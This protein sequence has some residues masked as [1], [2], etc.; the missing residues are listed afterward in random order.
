MDRFRAGRGRALYAVYWLGLSVLVLALDYALGPI[1]Q[2]PAAFIL[3]VS[4]AAWY[5]GRLWGLGLALVLPLC[6][7]YL[8]S[9]SDLP[10]TMGEASINAAIRMIVLGLFAVLVDRVAV[11]REAL[12]RRVEVL[13]GFLPVCVVCKRVRNEDDGAWCPVER[14]L[15]LRSPAD[16]RGPVCPDCAREAEEAFDRR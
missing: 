2:F 1:T 5:N 12:Q 9:L 16:R 6:R 15:R 13:E 14:F 7:L 3:P 10:W 11:Q 8:V 4:L